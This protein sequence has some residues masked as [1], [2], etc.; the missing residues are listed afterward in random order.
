MDVPPLVICTWSI[1]SKVYTILLCI[2]YA[3]MFSNR[4]Q[5]VLVFVRVLPYLRN[6]AHKL[7]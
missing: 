4:R 5:I 3:S 6:S 7:E 2:V 1:N